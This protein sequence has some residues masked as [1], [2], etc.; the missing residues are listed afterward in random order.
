MG[1]G[2]WSRPELRFF[3]TYA[4]WNDAARVAG[5]GSTDAAVASISSTGVF[6]NRNSGSTVGV[7]LEGW[8]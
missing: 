7:Q 8:W 1:R 6:A 2:F 5:E 3:Y 4:R